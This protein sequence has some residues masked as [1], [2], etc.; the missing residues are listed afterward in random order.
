M[1]Y[2]IN[3]LRRAEEGVTEVELEQL[4][5]SFETKELALQYIKDNLVLSELNEGRDVVVLDKDTEKYHYFEI[6]ND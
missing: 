6:I 1:A 3:A 4:S 5:D 2:K